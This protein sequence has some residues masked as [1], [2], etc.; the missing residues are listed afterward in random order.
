MIKWLGYAPDL[1]EKI[2]GVFTNCANVIP[3]IKGFAGAPSPQ[4]GLLSAALASTCQGAALL[5]KLDQSVRFFAGTG[6]KLYEASTSSWTDRTRASGGDYSPASDV[7]WRFAQYGDV[8][9]AAAKSDT[10]QFSSSGAFA[11]VSGAPKAAVVESANNFVFLFDT[12]EGTYSDSP[13]RWW[14]SALGDYTDWTPDVATQC[15]TGILSATAGKIRAGRRFGEAIIAYKERSMYLG[16]YVGPPNIWEFRLLPED[17]G[18]LSQEVVVDIGES[19]APKHIFMGYDDF[20][21]F[22]G[23]RAVPVGDARIR[24]TVFSSIKRSKQHISAAVHDRLRS[25]VYFFFPASDTLD[26]C[27]VYNYRTNEWGRDDREIAFPVEYQDPAFTYED[28]GTLYTTYDSLPNTSYGSGFTS[29]GSPSPAVIGTDNVLYTLTGASVSSSITTGDYGDD[30]VQSLLHR[31]KINY[32]SNPDSSQMVHY[33]KS[34]S[35]DDLTL[36]E[37]V[38]AT[39][40]R[41]DLLHEARWH[42]VRFDFTGDWEASGHRMGLQKSG[43]E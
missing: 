39:K 41:F 18:A 14:C 43:H 32:T 8:S 26:K 20:Y 40:D 6:T 9:L 30:D 23:A 29:E 35:G 1:D 24:N 27:V 13:N 12:N 22:D 4:V 28:V 34:D 2:P 5:K 10:L 15:A 42:R 11:D 3:T 38:P 19:E 21:V 33:F 36:G 17:A 37:T 16:V 25:L 31:V 7:R